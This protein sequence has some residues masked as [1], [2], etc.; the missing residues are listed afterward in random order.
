MQKRKDPLLTDPWFEARFYGQVSPESSRIA[1]PN[2]EPLTFAE[3]QGLFLFCPCGYG[4]PDSH[5][6]GLYVPF[7]NPPS[8]IPLPLDHGPVDKDGNHPRWTVSGSGLADL[9]LKPSI[10]V[11][12]PECWHGHITNGEVTT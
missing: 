6:H 3:S 7:K 1:H 10:A 4:K 11:G 9:T 2:G 5:A 8:G 12:K